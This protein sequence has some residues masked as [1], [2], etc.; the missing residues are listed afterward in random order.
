MPSGSELNDLYKESFAETGQ[1]QST[2]VPMALPNTTTD[3]HS[4]MSS[5]FRVAKS[6][7]L[8]AAKLLSP[9]A[10][11]SLPTTS[12]NS[13]SAA[14]PLVDKDFK[15]LPLPF[16]VDPGPNWNLL[17]NGN[18]EDVIKKMSQTDEEQMCLLK[19]Y[20]DVVELDINVESSPGGS[21]EV[22][23]QSNIG[24]TQDGQLNGPRKPSKLPVAVLPCDNQPSF[25]REVIT[26]YLHKIKER[27]DF[28]KETMIDEPIQTSNLKC[29]NDGCE[30]YGTIANN[31]LCTKCF[32]L[33][34]QS[35]VK[36]KDKGTSSGYPPTYSEAVGYDRVFYTP[37]MEGE[38]PTASA[39]SE[40]RATELLKEMSV[41]CQAPGCSFYGT[42]DK[43]GFC[44]KCFSANK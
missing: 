39:N 38:L 9:A 12:G 10:M 20:I 4:A 13:I 30:L 6:T 11:L 43:S 36:F 18:D 35:V 40:N 27:F 3:I 42:P 21:K 29:A 37:S 7:I 31:Y 8:Q 23:D 32:Q 2:K 16:A 26:G 22:S 5:I 15:L 41:K 17:E 44:S 19:K 34:S 25:Y 1:P 28:E 33:Q 14:I 24:K